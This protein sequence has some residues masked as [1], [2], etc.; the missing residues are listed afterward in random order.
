MPARLSI[1]TLVA[2]IGLSFAA[3]SLAPAAGADIGSR[4]PSFLGAGSNVSGS[5]PQSKLWW[6][7]GR[8]WASMWD[9]ASAD[10]HIFRHDGA[11]GW[12]DTGVQLDARN[13]SRADVLWDGSKLYVA[14]HVFTENP[15]G[16]FP[17]RFYRYSYN[18]ATKTYSRD[19]G[20]P[21]AINDFKTETV[22][23]EK[24]ST[25]RLWA[26][27]VQG[28]Q[29]YVNHTLGDDLTWSTPFVLP[30]ADTTV[31]VD[32]IS[33][34]VAFGGD[35]IGVMWSNQVT[36]SFHFA[37]HRDTDPVSTWTSGPVPGVT[38]A[39]DH[40]N[41]K[42]DSAGRVYAAVK[43]NVTPSSGQPMIVLLVRE[44]SGAWTNSTV[45][46]SGVSHTRPIVQLDE[47]NGIVHVLATGPQP[48]A[49][50]GQAGGDIYE[51]SATLTSLAF[52]P[53]AGTPVIRQDGNPDM[54]DVTS[55]KQGVN[56]LT[57]LPLLATENAT[58]F[59]WHTLVS[60][61][62]TMPP[63]AEF[64]AD[65][66]A[67][68]AP[69][70]VAFTDR[71]SGAPAGWAW[72]FGDG[73]ASTAQNPTH[74]YA[75]A[76]T[77]DVSL[78]A[79]NTNG[80]DTETKAGFITVT[81]GIPA[82]TADFS[83][84]PTSGAEPLAVTFTDLSTGSPSSWSWSFGDGATSTQP[85]PVHLYGVPG[86]Y[87][88]E[89]TV[90]NPT[91]SS[92]KTRAGLVTVTA[93]PAPVASFDGTPTVGTTPLTVG[94]SDRS[95]GVISSWAWDFGDGTTS[96]LASPPHVYAAAGTYDVS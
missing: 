94:F 64:S 84:T 59:Y 92:T 79:T 75:A 69:L 24:D 89:L 90:T 35:R 26:T 34:V 32:D 65:Q 73:G 47:L 81:A 45:S 29:V 66:A 58:D 46:L 10:F 42:A 19:A 72:N 20:F 78:V 12:A 86:T 96:T 83:A 93:L 61:V 67:G 39:D 25:G 76:G 77:Y 62:P 15:V 33:S 60:L 2:L 71:S 23:I 88:V 11:A 70:T 48:P 30:A 14:S 18:A 54:N 82:P 68:V 55:T 13:G 40:V 63:V 1:R 37:V 38:L 3:T 16:G 52:P 49:T 91:G 17:T 74:V 44:P 21:V 50:S 22:T 31:L 85:S 4:G 7:D 56:S 28:A 5:K 8:W 43:R 80:S 36:G 6:N 57:G 41:L 53:G 51:K 9:T 87:T 95:S 27:W